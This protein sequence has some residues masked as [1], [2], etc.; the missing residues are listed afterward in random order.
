MT[1]AS[2]VDVL[3]GPGGPGAV[4]HQH[5]IAARAVEVLGSEG[6]AS[7]W[8]RRPNRALGGKPPVALLDT[9]LGTQQV[10]AVLGRIE[11][12]VYS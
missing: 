12:G 4:E 5:G 6:K 3:G 2:I 8:L 11:H 1:P 9:D 7:R 10:E